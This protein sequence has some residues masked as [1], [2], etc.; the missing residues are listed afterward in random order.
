M[1]PTEIHGCAKK[2]ERQ[3]V[4]E[5]WVLSRRVMYLSSLRSSS[6]PLSLSL[7][8]YWRNA[9][10][11]PMSA[12]SERHFCTYERS[13]TKAIID[14]HAYVSKCRL[15]IIIRVM[16]Q[17]EDML[18][19]NFPKKRFF[20]DVFSVDILRR[21]NLDYR[22]LRYLAC[23]LHRRFCSLERKRSNI[24]IRSALLCLTLLTICTA[25]LECI[26]K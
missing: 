25:K 22:E 13:T 2:K 23:F 19:W 21:L 6:F 5:K 11:S 14:A 12:S 10:R 8:V 26:L 24:R 18:V 17:L 20:I 7:S 1:P 3:R 16:L 9:N 15:L 4:T